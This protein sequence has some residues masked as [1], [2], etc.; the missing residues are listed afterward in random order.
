MGVDGMRLDA[1][2]YLK[3]RDGTI[4][5]NLPETHEVLKTLR[6]ELDARYTD[7]FFLAEANQWP[8]DVREYSAMATSATSRTTSR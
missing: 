3:E 4:N 2:P 1:I 7:R 6:A 5:E 8:E